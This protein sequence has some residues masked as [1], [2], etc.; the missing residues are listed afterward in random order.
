[1]KLKKIMKTMMKKFLFFGLFAISLASCSSSA[2]DGQGRV[3]VKLTDAPF[4]FSFAT[5]AN[6]GISKIELKN[7]SSGQYITVYESSTNDSY[8]LLDYQNGKTATVETNNLPVGT[9]T[10]ARVT[11]NNAS[12][13]MNGNTASGNSFFNFS[14]EAQ[15]S[16][17]ETVNPSLVI[18]HTG[19]SNVLIDIN[20]NKTFQFQ[21]NGG[22]F[23]AW[24]NELSSIVGCT[25]RPEF[26][27]CDLDK[28][29]SISGNVTVNGTK[30]ANAIVTVTVGNKEVAANTDANGNYTIIGVQ[31]GTYSVN[32]TTTDGTSITNK[33]IV[34]TGT[35]KAT[36]T[37]KN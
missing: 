15:G 10:M 24:I 5:E 32:V 8:N 17:E 18:E 13:K 4:P 29:G 28:T 9:Y 3:N 23:S 30:T 27:V 7:D 6:V 16:Y 26:R 36:C 14:S 1:M 25:F 20:V 12:V 19:T 2:P 33:N 31:P 34:V 11:F 35:G 21:G 22:I 37:F